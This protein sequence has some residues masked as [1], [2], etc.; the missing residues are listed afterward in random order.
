MGLWKKMAI[1]WTQ[2]ADKQSVWI[3][4]VFWFAIALRAMDI[5]PAVAL[6]RIM[7]HVAGTLRWQTFL[8][9][10]L[11]CRPAEGYENFLRMMFVS[12]HWCRT[13]AGSD[14]QGSAKFWHILCSSHDFMTCKC[15]K[16]LIVRR[17]RWRDGSWLLFAPYF[18]GPCQAQ[19]GW[20]ENSCSACV[21]Q[22]RHVF[23]FKI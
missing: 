1:N 13:A 9:S 22:N 3:C 4:N 14:L 17:I 7:Q 2:T 18:A 8:L 16:L 21:V 5:I 12:V 15:R 20:N 11:A 19:T 10:T 6:G 23:M